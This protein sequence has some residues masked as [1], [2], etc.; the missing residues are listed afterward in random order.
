VD[1]LA[2]GSG[3]APG[4][5][6]R[7]K[8]TQD[9]RDSLDRADYALIDTDGVVAANNLADDAVTTR[10]IDDGAV[11]TDKLADGAVRTVKLNDG[12]VTSSKIYTGAVTE[13]KI[14]AGAVTTAKIRDGAVD[15][16]KLADGAVTSAKLYTG[17]VTESKIYFDAVTTAKIRDGAVTTQKLSSNV[18]ASLVPSGGASGQV[19][20]KASDAD[21]ALRWVDQSGGG[22]GSS[23]YADLTNKPQ[24]NGVTLSGDKSAA[25]IGLAT[26]S[27]IPTKT[28]DLT[29]DSGFITSAPEEVFWATPGTT[30]Y[31]QL[32]AAYQAKKVVLCDISG[33]VYRL[34]KR[35]AANSYDFS[36]VV[37]VL[38]DQYV[39]TFTVHNSTWGSPVAKKIPAAPE[40]VGAI[41]APASPSAGQFLV[42]NGTAWV[43]QTLTTWQGG[44]Y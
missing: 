35:N 27:Q 25:E 9:V 12:A 6:S 18:Q 36:A 5:V 29:N 14:Y 22:G 40:D 37:G 23:D 41:A 19:L 4:A 38:N 42:Y 17:A 34:T 32:D 7:G 44:S 33:T 20:A 15:T 13:A 43:A 31:E 11:G 1:G 10:T 26:P 16:D 30:T 24:I 2:D 3:L 21:H 39:N 8:L 28:S